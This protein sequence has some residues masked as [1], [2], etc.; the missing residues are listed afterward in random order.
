MAEV[1]AKLGCLNY[2]LDEQGHDAIDPYAL[3]W[4]SPMSGL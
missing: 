2:R 1:V 3:R 4:L